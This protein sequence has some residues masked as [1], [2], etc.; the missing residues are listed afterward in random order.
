MAVWLFFGIDKRR[1]NKKLIS[2]PFMRLP[3][4]TSSKHYSMKGSAKSSPFPLAASPLPSPPGV[5]CWRRLDHIGESS[6]PTASSHV[7]SLADPAC[8]KSSALQQRICLRTEP[9]TRELETSP[10]TPR[11]REQRPWTTS[12]RL[13]IL[14]RFFL[15]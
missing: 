10:P 5:T 4:F 12:Y 9:S 14:R 8:T 1:I 7:S 13:G 11:R 15:R 2:N 6:P 3:G